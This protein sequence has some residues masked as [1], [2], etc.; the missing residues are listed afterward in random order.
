[1]NIAIL[2]GLMGM[3]GFGIADF[4]AKKVIDK[5]GNVKTLFYAQ[6]IG[7]FL[8]LPYYIKNPALP[9][10]TTENIIYI[11]L[12][13][14][15]NF[16]SYI[17]LY[18]SFE[19]GK[20]SVVSPIASSFS[21]LAVIISFLFF[22]ETFPSLKIVALCL[23]LVGIFSTS[24]DFK[25]LK[26]GFQTS[27]FSKGVPQAF[28]FFLISGIYVP[29]WDRFLDRGGWFIWVI[30]VKLL[31]TFFAWVYL[32]TV[33][34]KTVKAPGKDIFL[35]VVLVAGLEAIGGFGNSWALETTSGTTSVVVSLTSALS[36]VTAVLA[37]IFLKER[38]VLNQYIG[39]V[40]IIGGL[41]LMPFI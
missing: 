17:F 11:L 20:I 1:M 18:K 36:V 29:L 30:I 8:A 34:K 39:I 15:F 27:D 9:E 3:F 31:I 40:L 28:A 21:I 14:L 23:V 19:L 37:Y 25:Q 7:V 10:F 4:F 32:T 5:I 22:G 26:D 35:W 6:L 13:G 38:L 16:I 12:F 41:V 2:G 24:I 33:E